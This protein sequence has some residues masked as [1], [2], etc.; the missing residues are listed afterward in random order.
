MGS[1]STFKLIGD[2]H[3]GDNLKIKREDR[4]G[5]ALAIYGEYE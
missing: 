1:G 4:S 2:I 5:H 3:F